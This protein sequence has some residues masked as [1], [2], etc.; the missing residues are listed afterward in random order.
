MLAVLVIALLASAAVAGLVGSAFI[1]PRGSFLRSRRG[2]WLIVLLAFGIVLL[3]PQLMAL[4]A[5]AGPMA[6]ALGPGVAFAWPDAIPKPVYFG[7]WVATSLVGLA[8][9]MRVW[10]IGTPEWRAGSAQLFDSSPASRVVSLLPLADSLE[11]AIDV[12]GRA[13]LSVRDAPT[14][15]PDVRKI[16][17]RFADEVP[18]RDGDAYR[19]VAEKM[20]SEVAALVTGYLLEG[21][22]RRMLR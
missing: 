13:H 7:L 10:K 21:A 14:V 11:D 1:A 2:V 17:R 15:A 9:G 19:M 12:L 6:G 8:V 4:D 5:A 3:P 16:G 20:P 18:P 22:G